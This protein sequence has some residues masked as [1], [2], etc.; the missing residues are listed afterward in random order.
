MR[1][2]KA[3]GRKREGRR[4]QGGGQTAGE[5]EE[6]KIDVILAPV[7]TIVKAAS[8]SIGTITTYGKYICITYVLH[9]KNMCDAVVWIHAG[10]VFTKNLT[11]LASIDC[12][13]EV[14][15]SSRRA[16]NSRVLDVKSMDFQ[17]PG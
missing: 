11:A 1:R 8:V 16:L 7:F 4:E 12:E 14:S 2:Q 6:V 3:V 10:A 15:E 9:M 13:V 17:P 5:R